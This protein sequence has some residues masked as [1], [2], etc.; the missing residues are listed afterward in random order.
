MSFLLDPPTLVIL[1]VL[2][3]IVEKRYHLGNRTLK[4]V[5]GVIVAVFWVFSSAL[6]LDVIMWYIPGLWNME[7]SVWM[8]HSNITGILKAEVPL[9]V[10]VLMFLLY[11]AWLYTGFLAEKKIFNPCTLDLTGP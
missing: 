8:F 4:I 2:L 11:P 6:Y 10:V 7:G 3:S 5:G 1:G 9:A